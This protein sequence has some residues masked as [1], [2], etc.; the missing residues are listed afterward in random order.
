MVQWMAFGLTLYVVWQRLKTVTR[1]Q[2]EPHVWIPAE[3]EFLL[4]APIPM[5]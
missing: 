3:R 1:K 2:F 4:T 5:R